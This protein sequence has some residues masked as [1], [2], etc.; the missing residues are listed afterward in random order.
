MTQSHRMAAA[1][2]CLLWT[3]ALA[4]T[5]T[6]RGAGDETNDVRTHLEEICQA[7]EAARQRGDAAAAK[8]LITTGATLLPIR[9]GES[10]SL[11][12]H[13]DAR[14]AN[15]KRNRRS[16]APATAVVHRAVQPVGSTAIVTELLRIEGPATIAPRRRTLVLVNKTGAWRIAHLHTSEYTRWK[17]AI[18]AFERRDQKSLPPPNAIVFV[19]SSSIRGWKSLKQDFPQ[20]DVLNR[21]FGGSQMIDSLL[22]AER[23][24]IRYR[25]RGVVVYAGDNDIAAG[26]SAERVAADFSRFVAT[27]HARLPETRIGF[28]AIKPSLRRWALWPAMRRANA[29]IADYASRRPHVDYLDIAAPMLSKEGTPREELFVKDGLHLTPQGYRVWTSV[30]TPWVQSVVQAKEKKGRQ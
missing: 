19:G 8:R 20:T 12:S 21:G 13:L 6:A 29:R 5:P 2:G 27:V 17:A 18:E 3:A 4:T 11:R 10:Q 26:K 25:P 24:V 14:A 30:L 1:L 28:I 15:R 9:G 23:I 22:Y 7:F 16:S